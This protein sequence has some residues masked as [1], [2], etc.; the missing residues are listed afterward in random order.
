MRLLRWLWVKEEKKAAHPSFKR[1]IS[2][3]AAK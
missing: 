1:N 2:I 3:S